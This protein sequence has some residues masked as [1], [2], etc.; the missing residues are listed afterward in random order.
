MDLKPEGQVKS[1]IRL[2]A[3]GEAGRLTKIVWCD[4]GLTRAPDGEDAN[5]V[6]DDRKQR[7]TCVVASCAEQELTQH[8]LELAG[9]RCERT[10]FWITS[11][12]EQCRQESVMPFLGG[13]RS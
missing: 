9:F 13:F 12:P 5:L 4:K 6:V 7:S 2:G 1:K 8:I 10:K 3:R 11:E